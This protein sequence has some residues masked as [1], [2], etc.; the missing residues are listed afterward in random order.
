MH[1][2]NTHKHALLEFIE[3]AQPSQTEDKGQSG[4]VASLQD[5]LTFLFSPISSL[6]H[7]SLLR[8]SSPLSRLDESGCEVLVIEG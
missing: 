1:R 2:T 4:Q 3:S 6:M 5:F 7:P 8:S